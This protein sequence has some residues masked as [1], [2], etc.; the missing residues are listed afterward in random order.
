MKRSHSSWSE[1]D[2]ELLKGCLAAGFTV[3]RTATKLKRTVLGVHAR[4]SKFGLRFATI[5]EQR[6][7]LKSKSES[8]AQYWGARLIYRVADPTTR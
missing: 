4:A 8:D 7:A 5:K 6:E 1:Q 2:D 3:N